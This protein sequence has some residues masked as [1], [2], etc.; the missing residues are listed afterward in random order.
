MTF[1]ELA[2]FVVNIC[3]GVLF[4]KVGAAKFGVAGGIGGFFLGF[5]IALC[6]WLA[7]GKL[8]SLWHPLRPVCKNGKCR[9]KDY[10]IV[11]ISAEGTIW[12]CKCGDKYIRKGRT[13]MRLTE[14]GDTEPYMAY[15]GLFGRWCSAKGK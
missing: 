15:N 10:E 5:G 6:F 3:V 9:A 11:E 1:I 8:L 4:A 12:V 14:D 13:F 2:F 7:L